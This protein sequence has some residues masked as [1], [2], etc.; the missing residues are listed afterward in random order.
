VVYLRWWSVGCGLWVVGMEGERAPPPH[1]IR[2][3][4]H[5]FTK[6]GLWY[7]GLEFFGGSGRGLFIFAFVFALAFVLRV[8]TWFLGFLG[9]RLVGR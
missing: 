1:V 7:F 6:L 5:E 4:S 2:C 3:G 9:S 8:L